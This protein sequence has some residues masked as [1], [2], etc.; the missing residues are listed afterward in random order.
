MIRLLLCA[1]VIP[2]CALEPPPRPPA[3]IPHAEIELHQWTKVVSV[4]VPGEVELTVQA[5]VDGRAA[6]GVPV[7]WSAPGALSLSAATTVTGASGAASVTVRPRVNES[8]AFSVMARAGDRFVSIGVSLLECIPDCPPDWCGFDGCVGVCGA[9][10]DG[11]YCPQDGVCQNGACVLECPAPA[12]PCPA[13]MGPAERDGAEVCC[14]CNAGGCAHGAENAWAGMQHIVNATQKYAFVD[15]AVN[16]VLLLKDDALVGASFGDGRCRHVDDGFPF[17]FPL[18]GHVAW[19]P[20]HEVV[21]V[22]DDGWQTGRIGGAIRSLDV[23]EEILALPD[24]SGEPTRFTVLST[25]ATSVTADI[26]LDDADRPG[27]G[28]PDAASVAAS[29][30]TVAAVLTEACP[31][32]ADTARRVHGW[33]LEAGAKNGFD[34]DGACCPQ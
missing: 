14:T 4:Q 18:K 24:W 34:I 12:M 29:F 16:L 21:A 1:S 5:S 19:L 17:P 9:C 20:M 28:E 11:T 8:G 3:P 6:V 30:T 23:E 33:V 27:C 25:I 22:S 2:G 13:G 10:S 32:E 31:I 26:H 15:G 7:A